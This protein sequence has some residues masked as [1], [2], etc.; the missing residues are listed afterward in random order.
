MPRYIDK[1]LKCNELLSVYNNEMA[2][3]ECIGAMEDRGIC[4]DYK[5]VTEGLKYEQSEIERA[6]AAFKE[7]T[8][9]EYQDSPKFFK[10]LFDERGELYGRTDKGNASFAGDVLEKLNTPTARLINRIRY[11][12]KRAG[13]YWSS[14]LY[15]ADSD[16]ILRATP[17]AAGTVTGR[18][19]YRNPNLQN[20]PKEDEEEDKDKPY[21]IRGSF[22]PRQGH[23]FVSIDYS[24]QEYRL[25][26][27]YANERS[28]IKLVNEGMDVHE[29]TAKML[30]IPRKQAKTIN[31]ALLYG[32]GIATLAQM[33]GVTESEAKSLRERYF[34]KLP[35]VKE[36]IKAVMQR[37][38]QN[39]FI[40]NWLGR[41]FW[42]N[43][44]DFAYKLPNY[45]IQGSG[46]DVVKRAMVET[47]K[48]APILIQIHDEIL[49]EIP[50]RDF[51]KITLICDIM[52]S[53]YK[54]R[55]GLGL[56]VSVK[57]SFKSF[58]NRDLV[59]GSPTA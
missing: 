25:M 1:S 3:I 59:D 36:F 10:G 34:S 57:H 24:Q 38:S 4:I 21:V 50:E 39:G 35:K 11:H 13:T 33:L 53:I 27:D 29:A 45:L 7:E 48:I 26:L 9:Y 20:L 17:N 43:S 6:K 37:G 51:E 16:G 54:P 55:N 47:Y 19:S 42:L 14:F 18:F 12:E 32:S 56:E 52:S 58:A 40:R 23:A 49:Y 5:Y 46:A 2:L 44:F 41:R 31:F 22:K 30:G 15:Y 8:G 28:L